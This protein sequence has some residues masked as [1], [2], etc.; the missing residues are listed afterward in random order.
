MP[1]ISELRQVD[2]QSGPIARLRWSHDGRYLAIPTERGSTAIFD[3]EAERVTQTLEGDSEV[4]AVG[5][6]PKSDLIMIGSAD[7]SIFVWELTSGTRTP[8]TNNGHEEAVHSLEWTDEGA[9]ALTCSPDRIRALDG[10]CLASGWSKEM[11]DGA[12]QYTGFTEATCSFQSSFLLASAA[13]QGTLLILRNLMSAELIDRIELAQ[14]VRSLAWSPAEDLL[15][16]GTGDGVLVIRASHEGFED[17]ADALTLDSPRVH[18]VAF[19]EDGRLLA[20]RD[21][22]GLKIWDVRGG[23]LVLALEESIRVLPGNRL[24]PGIAFNPTRPLLATV[25][26][27]GTAFRIVDLNHVGLAPAG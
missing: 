16:V 2:L 5:W 24:P 18:A 22:K 26:P 12:N 8:Y 1:E 25:M 10:C 4:T 20:S 9:L 6:D 19:S 14:P 13:D 21:A 11:E 7:R 27:N 23:R 17:R 3:V 15:A